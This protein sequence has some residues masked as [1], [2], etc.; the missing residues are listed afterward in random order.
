MIAT[1]AIPLMV[2]Y[3]PPGTKEAVSAVLDSRWIG[4]GPLVDKFERRFSEY[5]GRPCVAVSSCT[6]ALHLAYILAGIGPGDE[7]IAPLFTCTATNEPLLWM[8][9]KIRFCDVAPNSLNMD[10]ERA[11]SLITERTKA[12]VVV[13]Y[14]GM[15]ANRTLFRLGLPSIEDCAQAIGPGWAGQAGEFACFSFQAVKHLTTQ[16]GGMLALPISLTRRARCLRWFGIDRA[17]KLAGNWDNDITEVGYKY[18]LG[19]MSAAMGLHALPGLT[20][21]ITYRRSLRDAY[22]SNLSDLGGIQVI[23]QDEN[24]ACWLMTVLVERRE[25]LM[26]KLREEG[27]ECDLVHYRNDRYTIFKDFRGEFPNMD[28]IDGKYLCLP[29]HMWMDVEDVG[30]ICEVIRGGW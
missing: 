24:S 15:P 27:I 19:D 1:K 6:A 2:P 13:H 11:K 14:G 8:G 10:V 22:R 16:D 4:Q 17:A 9:A 12:I 3:I 23:D 28:A 21:Q 5:I 26:A 25:S 29:L 7:V 20:A 30:R 18:Q